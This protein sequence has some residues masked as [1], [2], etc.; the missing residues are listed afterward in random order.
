VT[1]GGAVEWLAA[2]A[3]QRASDGLHRQL[4]PR[5]AALFSSATLVDLASNDYLGLARDPRV[6]AAAVEAA[7][8]WGAGSTGSRLVTGSTALHEQL[9]AELADLVGAPTALVFSS[10]YT[11]NLA[12]VSALAGPQCLIVSD[13]SSHASL[14][15]GCRLA[16]SRVVVTRRGG[17][18]DARTALAKRTE[19]RALVVLDAVNSIDGTVA[20]LAA[21]HQVTREF[22]GLLLVDDA[23]GL[24]VRG[25]GRG[26][27]AE[28]GLS[29]EADVVTTV[30]L[31]K[32]LG[33][34]GGA[35]LGASAV[36]DHLIDTARS[37]VFD[38]GL[39]PAAAGAARAAVRIIA[40]QPELAK[41]V[42]TNA[43][44][45]AALSGVPVT[46]SAVVPVVL[47]G[48]ERALAAA[49]RLREDGVL[50]GCFRPPSVPPG[51]SRLRVTARAD[52]TEAEL[53][54]YGSAVAGWIGPASG[55]PQR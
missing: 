13:A 42:L 37:F 45:I 11:A 5:T 23:H 49:R 10:G 28:A 54:R 40:A 6:V 33:S 29:A 8:T 38:T 22:G 2:A 55:D 53:A 46:D 15:D 25:S 30:T 31:S 14:I 21:W 39:N 32:S 36:R 4:S 16:R 52:L 47:G 26:S 1:G 44:I 51:T 3:A 48:A 19:Q 7:Q 20:D 17:V 50:V 34:Q 9:E 18:D 24:G 35:V 12:A 43:M 41:Q 27:V